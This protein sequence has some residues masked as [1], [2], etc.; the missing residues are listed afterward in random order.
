MPDYSKSSGDLRSYEK[1]YRI[2][3]ESRGFEKKKFKKYSK[4]CTCIKINENGN[5]YGDEGALQM[6]RYRYPT[7]NPMEYD[8]VLKRIDKER[9]GSYRYINN[10]Q[11]RETEQEKSRGARLSLEAGTNDGV[12]FVSVDGDNVVNHNRNKSAEVLEKVGYGLGVASDV[13]Q[14]VGERVGSTFGGQMAKAVLDQVS[15]GLGLASN[16]AQEVA[17]QKRA[18]SRKRR[19]SDGTRLAADRIIQVSNGTKRIEEI[20]NILVGAVGE[21][22]RTC[23]VDVIINGDYRLAKSKYRALKNTTAVRE[24]IRRVARLISGVLNTS[25]GLVDSLGPLFIG[26]VASRVVACSLNNAGNTVTKI[27]SLKQTT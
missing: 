24:K 15:F 16:T 4:K 13:V 1:Y 20:V 3:D 21:N 17:E 27:N 2:P 25:A 26:P 9:F 12:G 19:E 5:G 7:D 18:R 11:R 10:R 22:F 8:D 23:I 6:D 14:K